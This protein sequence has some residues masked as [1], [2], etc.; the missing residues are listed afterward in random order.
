MAH[1]IAQ[2]FFIWPPGHIAPLSPE[3]EDLMFL[4]G[5]VQEE[6]DFESMVKSGVIREQHDEF[7]VLHNPPKLG[8]RVKY[9][10]AIWQIAGIQTY[11]PDIKSS[12]ENFYV[13]VCTQDGEAFELKNS[14]TVPCIPVF[15][16]GS[17]AIQDRCVEKYVVK[18]PHIPKIQFPELQVLDRHTF[19]PSDCDSYQYDYVVLC[20]C[21]A[22]ALSTVAA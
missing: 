17:L 19:H 2:L 9:Q 4:H 8:D 5:F 11:E 18:R 10:E 16:N 22:V 20:W 6:I 1:F 15:E 12:I 3:E 13:L 14:E 21:R 7:R